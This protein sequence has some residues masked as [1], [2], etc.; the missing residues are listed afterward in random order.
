MRVLCITL[1]FLLLTSVAYLVAVRG[2]FFIVLINSVISIVS[3]LLYLILS[4]PDIGLT[5]MCISCCLSTIFY[6]FALIYISSQKS[7]EKRVI[8][9]GTK[10]R[11]FL[12]ALTIP[13]TLI[14][15]QL[16]SLLPKISYFYNLELAGNFYIN[17]SFKDFK[18]DS[19]VTTII[20]GYRALDTVLETIVILTTSFI[21]KNIFSSKQE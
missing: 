15:Y 2:L 1:L 4:A 13:M 20:A 17:N 14:M 21:L 3:V 12:L 11:I 7:I 6:I 19:I 10:K 5:E 9:D 16:I 8:N 18:I